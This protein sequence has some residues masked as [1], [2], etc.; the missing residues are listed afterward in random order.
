MTP[1]RLCLVSPKMGAIFGRE[2]KFLTGSIPEY[3]PVSL[4][5]LKITNRCQP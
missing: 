2:L 5:W 3:G 1:P 4:I